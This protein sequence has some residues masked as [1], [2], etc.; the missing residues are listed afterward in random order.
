MF[1]FDFLNFIFKFDFLKFLRFS[2]I[3]F[4]IREANQKGKHN[5][6]CP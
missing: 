4:N 5:N 6:S 1:L 3:S 2:V